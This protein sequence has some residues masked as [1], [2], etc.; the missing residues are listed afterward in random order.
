MAPS[1]LCRILRGGQRPVLRSW[2]LLPPTVS[3][4][5]AALTAELC[6]HQCDAQAF[7]L[8]DGVL[9]RRSQRARQPPRHAKRG[10][11]FRRYNACRF[12]VGR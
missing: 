2:T 3:T 10:A 1:A 9:G 7:R 12:R 8:I 11:P 4:H 5:Y 6:L